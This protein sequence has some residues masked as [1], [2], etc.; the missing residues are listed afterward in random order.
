MKQNILNAW[1]GGAV[2]L[3]G[4]IALSPDTLYLSTIGSMW[5]IIGA[6][7]AAYHLSREVELHA[8]HTYCE[9]LTR[10]PDDQEIVAIMND[11]VQHYQE[12][13]WAMEK[14]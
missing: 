13:N 9:Y 4:L 14:L 7:R 6:P 10:Y 3:I 1:R 12:L 5:Y 2:I 11:E 8:V